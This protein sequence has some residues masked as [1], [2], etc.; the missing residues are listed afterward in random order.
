MPMI[1]DKP[2]VIYDR[3]VR[4]TAAVNL[5]FAGAGIWLALRFG[6]G[7]SL[8]LSVGFLGLFS[9]FWIKDLFFGF[10]LKLLC[11]DRTLHWQ[12][13][14]KTGSVPLTEIRKVRIG[15]GMPVQCGDGP[16]LQSTHV[17]FMLRSGAEEALPPNIAQGLR[18]WNWRHLKRL[19][20][21]IRTVTPVQVESISEPGVTAEGWENELGGAVNAASPHR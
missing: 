11:D 6:S 5:A 8:Y 15:V 10:R 1:A 21:Y 17:R 18:S 14:K 12:E 19:L 4:W 20:A 3:R 13:G 16:V 2:L 7:I 9:L